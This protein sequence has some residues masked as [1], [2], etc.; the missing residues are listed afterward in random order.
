MGNSMMLPLPSSSLII[1]IIALLLSPTT[2]AFTHL[3]T[4]NAFRQRHFHHLSLP[5]RHH[6]PLHTT[7]ASSSSSST[8]T[9]PPPAPPPPPSLNDRILSLAVP[10]IGVLALDPAMNTVD[11][12]FVGR[13]PDVT[14]LSAF[15]L[16]AQIFS[17]CVY[18]TG[19]LATITTPNVAAFRAQGKDAEARKLVTQVGPRWW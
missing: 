15:G 8:T 10:A 9:S 3:T 14:E 18:L 2:Q 4:P 19:F 7:R 5:S 12:V 17:A 16:N 13:L 11:T 1:I 6:A